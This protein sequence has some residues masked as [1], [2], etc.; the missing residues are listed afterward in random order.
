VLRAVL[1]VDVYTGTTASGDTDLPM[2]VCELAPMS[3]DLAGS[4]GIM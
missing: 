4:G 3:T 1:G 2:Q